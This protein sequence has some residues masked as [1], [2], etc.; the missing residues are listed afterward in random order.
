[1]IDISEDALVVA[2]K[3]YDYCIEKDQIEKNIDV[4]LSQ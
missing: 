2:K 4:I 1:L 3:N